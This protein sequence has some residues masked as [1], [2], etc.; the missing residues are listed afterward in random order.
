MTSAAN[1]TIHIRFYLTLRNDTIVHIS[2]FDFEF[3]LSKTLPSVCN[4]EEPCSIKKLELYSGYWN[5]IMDYVQNKLLKQ[6]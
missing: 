5:Y 4:S 2:S 6:I 3:S 1:S